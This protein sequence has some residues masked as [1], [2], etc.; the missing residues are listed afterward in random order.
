MSSELWG[1]TYLF[2]PCLFLSFIEHRDWS[3]DFNSSLWVCSDLSSISRKQNKGL[4]P[5]NSKFASLF[6]SFL[7]LTYRG[8][9][10]T[11]RWWTAHVHSAETLASARTEEHL[12]TPA[13]SCR[14]G[15]KDNSHF[16]RGLKFCYILLSVTNPIIAHPR[17]LVESFYLKILIMKLILKRQIE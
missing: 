10:L 16:P 8:V 12:I 4:Y 5:P 1:L 11:W 15:W 14:P 3:S 2:D 17:N 13:W 6:W 7:P 9:K